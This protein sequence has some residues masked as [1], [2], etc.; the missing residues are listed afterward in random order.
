MAKKI[1]WSNLAVDRYKEVIQYL[2]AEWS[3]REAA[4]FINQVDNKLFLLSRFPNIGRRTSQDPFIR[5]I[6]LSRHNRLNY[7]IE[8][9]RI[10]V[11]DIYDTR[12]AE[13]N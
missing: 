13:K 7:K 9:I 12:Q 2:L 11:L 6:L 10:I 8:K 3:E 5:Q 4:L 1:I